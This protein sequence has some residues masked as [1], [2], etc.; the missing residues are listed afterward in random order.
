MESK[1]ENPNLKLAKTI[2]EKFMETEQVK[3][4]KQIARFKLFHSSSWYGNGC[5]YC[6]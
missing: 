4:G 1:L 3:L 6:S 5:R 2:T